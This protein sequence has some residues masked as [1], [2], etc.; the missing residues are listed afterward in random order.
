[1]ASIKLIKLKYP[2]FKNNQL[3]QQLN[4]KANQ[5]KESTLV[6]CSQAESPEQSPEQPQAPLSDSESSS[7]LPKKGTEERAPLQVSDIWH[8]QK[9]LWASSKEMESL[10]SRSHLSPQLNSISTKYIRPICIQERRGISWGMDRSYCAVASPASPPHSWR[11]QLIWL[12]PIL[13]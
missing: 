7:K 4:Q 1:M 11:I 3:C 13:R 2:K 8:R 12:R 10:F 9:E 6:T 5:K